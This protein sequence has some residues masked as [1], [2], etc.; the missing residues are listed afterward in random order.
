M[1]VTFTPPIDP[2]PSTGVATKFNRYEA[3]YG[4]GYVQM[5]PAGTNFEK[6]SATLQ[7]PVLTHAQAD[8]IEAQ[9]RLAF[10]V[11][12]IYYAVPPSVQVK[13]WACGEWTRTE[14]DQQISSISCPFEEIF[15]P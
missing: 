15:N 10:G 3:R 2:A 9:L 5:A 4:D 12:V 14:V 11:D 13:A 8:D 1:A 7:W 6:E